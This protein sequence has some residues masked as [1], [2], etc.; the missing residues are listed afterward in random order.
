MKATDVSN[1]NKCVY[2]G[3]LAS[4]LN[5]TSGRQGFFIT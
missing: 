3:K 2:M 1:S 4:L 5:L